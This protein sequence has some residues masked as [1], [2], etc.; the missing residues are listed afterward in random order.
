MGFKVNLDGVDVNAF[1][2]I[3]ASTY[4]AF[5]TDGEVKESGPQSKNPGSQYINWEFTISEGTYENRKQWMNTSL[6]PQA[7]FG[8]KALL[9][10]TGRFSEAQLSGEIDFDIADVIGSEVLIVVKIKEYNGEDRNEVKSVRAVGAAVGATTRS[11][12]LLP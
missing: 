12:S 1:D 7:L 2:P 4:K 10:A 5:V 6:L 8:I 11:G 3:P 9:Q